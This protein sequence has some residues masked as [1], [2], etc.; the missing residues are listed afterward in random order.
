MNSPRGRLACLV[1]IDLLLTIRV[2][3]YNDHVM[4]RRYF[5][6]I[7]VMGYSAAPGLMMPVLL[8]WTLVRKGGVI[9]T[10]ISGWALSTH[11]C[12]VL[13]LVVSMSMKSCLLWKEVYFCLI[14]FKVSAL[15]CRSFIIFLWLLYWVV[16]RDIASF[17]Q[18]RLQKRTPTHNVCC[19]WFR[20]M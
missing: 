16:D 10:S 17:S 5:A 3:E 8:Q 15:T 9:L 13:W 2:H 14:D 4:S 11:V 18:P 12:T 1:D 7:T 20:W 6:G 19:W